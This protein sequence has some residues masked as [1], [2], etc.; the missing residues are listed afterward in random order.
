MC[1]KTASQK[2]LGE[3]KLKANTCLLLAFGGVWIIKTELTVN[4]RKFA[5]NH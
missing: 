4:E 1:K 2:V 5:C 3:D